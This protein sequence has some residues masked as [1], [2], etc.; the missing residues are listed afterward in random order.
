MLNS[1][2][3][4]RRQIKL[5][6]TISSEKAKLGFILRRILALIWLIIHLKVIF[7]LL[8]QRHT[9]RFKVIVKT[10][11]CLD[12]AIV[13]PINIM[14][15]PRRPTNFRQGQ[16]VG[17]R[18]ILGNDSIPLIS[19]VVNGLSEIKIGCKEWVNI[20]TYNLGFIQQS[21]KPDN[22]AIRIE[23]LRVSLHSANQ[24]MAWN[25]CFGETNIF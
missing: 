10:F 6:I 21:M 1:I 19:H 16:L 8:R 24:H 20:D 3:L 9:P 25:V 23:K 18:S 4:S 2:S 11:R 7:S 15:S 14:I 17:D 13:A 12:A 5:W 22:V